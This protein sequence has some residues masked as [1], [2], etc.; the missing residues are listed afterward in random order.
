MKTLACCTLTSLLLLP[1]AATPRAWAAETLPP[2]AAAES[3]DDA[4]ANGTR[5]MNEQR[6]PDAISAFNL[7]IA[8]KG[9]KRVDAAL[10]WKAYCLLKMS[11]TAEAA[12]S[13]DAL[14]TRFPASSW[15][16][17]C[18]ALTVASGSS[19][20]AGTSVSEGGIGAPQT[21]SDDDLKL[22]ALNSLAQQDPARAIPIIRRILTG[23][24][25][26]EFKKHALFS[27]SQSRSPEAASL[28]K[29]AVNGKLGTAVQIDAIRS[30]GLFEGKRANASL[31]TVYNS[32]QDVAI[33]QAVV[34]A[35]FLSNDAPR[36]V[37]LAR[38]EKNLELKQSIVQRLSMMHDKAATDYMLE[39]LK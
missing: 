18:G 20:A 5:A 27:L 36:L 11:R 31:A 12:A 34:T 19:A 24:Q 23:D 4:F 35:F 33:K 22:L 3:S 38:N 10:Y 21:G 26:E 2:A 39:L 9:S 30:A 28:L 8:S 37:E 7:V 14:R 29:D 25:S 6:W 32:T 13:C 17:D 1:L 16:Q 15:N